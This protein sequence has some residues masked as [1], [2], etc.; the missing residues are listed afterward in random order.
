MIPK[1]A[2]SW[3]R[4]HVSQRC[5]MRGRSNGPLI[6]HTAVGRTANAVMKREKPAGAGAVGSATLASHQASKIRDPMPCLAMITHAKAAR[7]QSRC[8]DLRVTVRCS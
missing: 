5:V 3:R 4:R 6:P 7:G 2:G 8:A 1:E